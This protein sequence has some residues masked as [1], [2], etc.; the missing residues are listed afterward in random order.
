MGWRGGELKSFDPEVFD[1]GEGGGTHIWQQTRRREQMISETMKTKRLLILKII[2]TSLRT[3]RRAL[4]PLPPFLILF[5]LPPH[6][7]SSPPCR[8]KKTK[9]GRDS[10]EWK[11]GPGV[12]SRAAFPVPV[13]EMLSDDM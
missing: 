3:V 12:F 7:L 6:G 10:F 8:E 9:T 2:R 11:E 4:V 13:R 1:K 5:S